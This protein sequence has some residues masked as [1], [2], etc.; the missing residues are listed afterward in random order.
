MHRSEYKPR[1]KRRTAKLDENMEKCPMHL[2]GDGGLLLYVVEGPSA[3]KVTQ[4]SK[5]QQ[6]NWRRH[7]S[8]HFFPTPTSKTSI[9]LYPLQEVQIIG[10]R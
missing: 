4:G 8:I 1:V 9:V 6:F 7:L 3:S 2:S 10:I 5:Y